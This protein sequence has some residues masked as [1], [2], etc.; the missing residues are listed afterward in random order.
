M[1]RIGFQLINPEHVS[2]KVLCA[3][4]FSCGKEMGQ[5]KYYWE[6]YREGDNDEWIIVEN[7]DQHVTG[8]NHIYECY[9]SRLSGPQCQSTSS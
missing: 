3:D 4:K 6:I 7:L 1:P 8:I 5:L 9:I 2:M